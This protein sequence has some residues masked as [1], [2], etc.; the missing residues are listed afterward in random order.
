MMTVWRIQLWL[1]YL[2]REDI[3]RFGKQLCEALPE[4]G[5]AAELLDILK[6]SRYKELGL[7][8]RDLHRILRHITECLPFVEY[9]TPR[10]QSGKILTIS[11]CN[12]YLEFSTNLSAA[13][14]C[15][16]HG[17]DV[18]MLPNPNEGKTPDFILVK[19]D[20]Y[21]AYELKTIYSAAS[22]WERMSS[23]LQQSDRI[24]LDMVDTPSS[25]YITHQLKSFAMTNKKIV[26][27]M[28][29]KGN[30]ELHVTPQM[31]SSPSFIERFMRLWNK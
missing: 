31:A 6:I 8:S 15:A 30:K 14:K 22:I 21:Y 9:S 25:R 1:D 4:P 11:G 10:Q 29:F 19:K 26:D 24:L 13:K 27:I 23:A 12:N 2:E 20:R 28:I 5:N 16:S 7:S 18:Y 17:Y 3:A